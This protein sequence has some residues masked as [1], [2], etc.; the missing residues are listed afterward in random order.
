MDQYYSLKSIRLIWCSTGG[1]FV[2]VGKILLNIT[3]K[4]NTISDK[5]KWFFFICLMKKDRDK[6]KMTKKI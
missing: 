1:E 2:E 5:S 6:K 4:K 3:Y